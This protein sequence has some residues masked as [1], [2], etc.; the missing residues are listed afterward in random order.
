LAV[1]KQ[2]TE[3]EAAARTL[4]VVSL[5]PFELSNLE[6]L[7]IGGYSPLEGFMTRADYACVVH[8]M[9]LASGLPWTLPITLAATSDM[10]QSLR[11]K[12][13]V[14]LAGAT[15]EPHVRPAG[16]TPIRG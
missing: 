14:A 8:D 6:M 11:G 4:P 10:V 12:G 13:R 2:A 1:G 15:G 3:L 5:N 9:R 7:A 16:T